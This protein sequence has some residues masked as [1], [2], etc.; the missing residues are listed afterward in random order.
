MD[1]QI[2]S[3]FFD[4]C[5]YL[6]QDN[7]EEAEQCFGKA[8]GY[9]YLAKD[10]SL[11]ELSVQTRV[12]QC[13]DYCYIHSNLQNIITQFSM[14]RNEFTSKLRAYGEIHELIGETMPYIEKL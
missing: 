8:M 3:L 12:K 14:V 10:K 9:A 2:K 13:D 11:C 5:E 1:K 6:L 7:W 4:G